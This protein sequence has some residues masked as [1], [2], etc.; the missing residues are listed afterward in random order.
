MRVLVRTSRWAIWSRRMGS[1]ALPLLVI[2]VFLHRSRAIDSRTFEVILAVASAFALIALLT[3]LVAFVSLWFTGDRGW[4]RAT[5]GIVLGLI[6]LTPLGYA[7]IQGLR[8]PFTT[9]VSTDWSDPPQLLAAG[10]PDVPLES[11]A[12]LAEAFPNAVNR[13]YQAEAD[14][15]HALAEELM[16]GRGWDIRIR[17]EPS[18]FGRPGVLNATAQTWMGWRDEIG[19]EVISSAVGARVSMRSRSSRGMHDLGMNGRR[20]EAFLLDLDTRVSDWNR[21][22]PEGEGD[23]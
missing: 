17:R 10:A 1:F 23:E 11:R 2:P 14:R 20:V 4:G 22:N 15:V 12:A 13:S 3:G 18:E 5:T 19:L 16:V 9:E 21:E 6:C 8:Y 7:G